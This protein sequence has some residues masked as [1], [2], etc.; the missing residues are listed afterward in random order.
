M[1]T[2]ILFLLIVLVLSSTATTFAAST[3]MS[4]IPSNGEI[5]KPF[6][7]DILIDAH[8]ERFNAAESTVALSDSLFINDIILGDCNFSFLQT[9]TI[10]NPSFQGVILGNYSTKCTVY[11]MVVIPTNK[12]K[13]TISFKNSVVRRYGDAKNI[14]KS[15]TNGVYTNT[16]VLSA[17]T[18]KSLEKE[19]NSG[20]YSLVLKI[21]NESGSSLTDK[22]V[23]LNTVNEKFP[24]SSYTDKNGIVKYSNLQPGIYSASVDS[25]KTIV[26]LRGKDHTVSL[27]IRYKSDSISIF[28]KKFELKHVVSFSFL[29]I[30]SL[31]LVLIIIIKRKKLGLEYLR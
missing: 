29:V 14:L 27:T 30:I 11:T 23:T 3:S 7:V 5:E 18:E 17:Q 28:G 25:Q 21:I 20:T 1:S 12:G 9:P 24:L 4:V 31:L 13:G 6:K 16:D 8:G 15:V 10:N 22:K 19:N 2:R 26:N